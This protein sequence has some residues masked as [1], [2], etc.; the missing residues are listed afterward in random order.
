MKLLKTFFV[1]IFL[2]VSFNAQVNT[3]KDVRD[4]IS[5][6]ELVTL[7]ESIP[8][9]EAIEVLSK[10][11]EKMTGKKIVPTVQLEVPIGVQ[12]TNMPYWKAMVII[13]QYHNL[14]FEERQDV[15]VITLKTAAG[16]DLSED[17]YAPVGSREVKISAIIFEADIGH[18]RE[19]GINWELIL[20]QNGLTIGGEL[21][22]TTEARE[23]TEETQIDLSRRPEFT[24]G[25]ETEFTTGDFTGN[26]T[27]LFKFFEEENMGEIVSRPSVT[28]RDKKLGR[29]QIGSDVSVKQRDFAGNVIDQFYPTGTIVEVTPHIYSEDGVDY[30]LLKIMVEKSSADIAQGGTNIEINKTTASTEVLMLNGEQTVIGGL[31]V[32]STVTVRNGIPF[33][34]DLPWWV[35][36]IRYLAGYDQDVLQQKEVIILLQADLMPTLKD[37]IATKKQNKFY[38]E[39]LNNMNDVNYYL[40]EQ[41]RFKKTIEEQKKAAEEAKEKEEVPD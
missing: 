30:I 20:Q 18:M 14:K 11:S 34:K 31:L 26:F 33:L 36:G 29:I 37:R 8:F 16:E 12:I 10:I 7:S 15:I 22:T 24:F 5:P 32:N 41:A 35:L 6:E 17:I 1:L 38:Q 23:L 3:E 21:I 39:R 40:E 9:N 25:P 27:A 28:V 19:R 13:T 2:T 4:Y